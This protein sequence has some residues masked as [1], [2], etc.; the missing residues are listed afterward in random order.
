MLI[1]FPPL[2]SGQ[3][4]YSGQI[5]WSQ[6]V[7]Y[8]EVPLYIRTYTPACNTTLTTVHTHRI[9]AIEHGRLCICLQNNLIIC[10]RHS[11]GVT[12]VTINEIFLGQSTK[13]I[14]YWLQYKTATA[15]PSLVTWLK[16][17][18]KTRCVHC[19]LP[20]C[21][22]M[23]SQLSVSPG[24]QTPIFF[25][26]SYAVIWYCFPT[27]FKTPSLSKTWPFSNLPPNT[28]PSPTSSKHTPFPHLLQTYPFPHLLQT[29]P[30]PPPPPNT[31]FYHLL[32]TH[33]LPPPPPN[34]PASSTS[35]KHTC[36]LHPVLSTVTLPN[37]HL[38]TKTHSL[39]CP[40][41]HYNC[42]E[43]SEAMKKTSSLHTQHPS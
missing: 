40:K 22:V 24:I 18:R 30:L 3:P 17:Y 15:S 16:S 33:L 25:S 42:K 34:T 12:R 29:H 26:F 35:S 19:C 7:L 1:H 28:P 20:N 13:C 14:P 9:V 5:T 38:W 2:K 6:C 41:N 27:F 43:Q 10:L 36:F 11:P 37:P 31:P 23:K 21:S 8:R 32:Q 39:T 4:L